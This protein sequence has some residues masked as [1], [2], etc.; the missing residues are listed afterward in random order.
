VSLLQTSVT[1]GASGPLIVLSGVAD[2]STITQLSG[3]I[4][5]QLSE[6]TRQLM[7]DASGLRFA[8]SAAVALLLLVARTLK[9]Q[10]GTMVLIRPQPAVARAVTLADPGQIILIQGRTP[11]TPE[12]EGGGGSLELGPR[13]RD[14]PSIP[15]SAGAAWTARSPGHGGWPRCIGCLRAAGFTRISL[16]SPQGVGLVAEAAQDVVG[17]AGELAGGVRMQGGRSLSP[18]EETSLTGTI[19]TAPW[20]SEGALV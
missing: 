7:I 13:C 9:G 12:S 3:V 17:A 15:G 20:A 8:D 16:T 11:R 18:K 2:I 5:S 6:I 4:T 14:L 1:A 10:G 19:F